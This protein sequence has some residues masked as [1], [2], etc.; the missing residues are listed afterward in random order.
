MV[1]LCICIVINLGLDLAVSW[2]NL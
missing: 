1:N 2:Q